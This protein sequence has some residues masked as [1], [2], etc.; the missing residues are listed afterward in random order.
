MNKL[1]LSSLKDLWVLEAKQG[2]S[3]LSGFGLFLTLCFL[4]EMGSTV[5]TSVPETTASS[6]TVPVETTT[7]GMYRGICDGVINPWW[8]LKTL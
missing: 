5:T 6:T 1:V 4:S 7:G 2:H 8:K 3:T